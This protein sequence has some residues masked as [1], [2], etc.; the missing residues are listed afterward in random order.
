MKKWA[1]IA[2]VAGLTVLTGC[3]GEDGG[4]G[5]TVATTPINSNN[6]TSCNTGVAGGYGFSPSTGNRVDC[7]IAQVN[8]GSFINSSNE[9]IYCSRDHRYYSNSNCATGDN[10][11]RICN[12]FESARGYWVNHRGFPQSCNNT[13][14]GNFGFDNWTGSAADAT[15]KCQDAY[16]TTYRAVVF[17]GLRQLKCVSYGFINYH[18]AFNYQFNVNLNYGF[19]T[20]ALYHNHLF[21]NNFANTYRGCQIGASNCNCVGISGTLGHL[22]FGMCM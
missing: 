20:Q 15:K 4:G 13:Y 9:L 21:Y 6:S 12:T 8:A 16:G 17:D 14:A 1:L 3:P 2:I 7:T 18:V 10:T 22:S 19:N 11:A 5:D